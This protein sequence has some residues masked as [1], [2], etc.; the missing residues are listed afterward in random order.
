[1]NKLKGDDEVEINNHKG[2]LRGREGL[3]TIIDYYFVI[4]F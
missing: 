4:S 2:S 1:M 3:M